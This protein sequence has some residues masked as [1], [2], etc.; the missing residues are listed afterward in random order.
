M[1]FPPVSKI[2]MQERQEGGHIHSPNRIA[3]GWDRASHTPLAALKVNGR[4][5]HGNVIRNC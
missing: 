1:P 5:E 2:F 4:R 3:A